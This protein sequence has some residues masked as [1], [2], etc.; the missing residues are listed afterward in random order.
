MTYSMNLGQII[1]IILSNLVLMV[2]AVWRL[3]ASMQKVETQLV[4]VNDKMEIVNKYHDQEISGLK[5]QIN[6]FHET[7][8]D[9]Q[10]RMTALELIVRIGNK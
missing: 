10:Q 3:S 5:S 7:T 2:A 4:G 1:T 6:G 9:L 8:K